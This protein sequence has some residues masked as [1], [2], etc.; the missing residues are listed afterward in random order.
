[1]RRIIRTHLRFFSEAMSESFDLRGANI[2]NL[3]LTGGYLSQERDIRSTL[4]LFSKLLEV[5]GTV[6]PTAD[7]TAHLAVRLDDESVI[8]GQ[9]LITGKEAAPLSRPVRE[10]FLVNQLVGGVRTQVEAGAQALKQIQRAD[11]ICFPMGSFFSSLLANLLP[12]G[13]GATLAKTGCPKVF[14][15]N[16]GHDPEQIGLGVER[17]V[18]IL[19]DTLSADCEPGAVFPPLL[20]TARPL[21]EAVRPLLD[22]VL[23]DTKNGKY[24]H[25]IDKSSIE[26]LG[27]Q[28]IDT[29]LIDPSSGRF[30][31]TPRLL[32]EILVTLAQ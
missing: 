14:I 21:Q 3:L 2:G 22:A 5:R 29:Q 30:G 28:I 18:R 23:L 25:P 32:S 19:L 4:F 20:D 16:M 9:H 13:I 15:P 8:V 1:M 17:S 24:E 10:C 27:V 26:A 31:I 6:L 11:L 12:K 7:S